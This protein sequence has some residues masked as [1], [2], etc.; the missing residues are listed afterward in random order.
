[1]GGQRLRLNLDPADQ[2]LTI[3]TDGT[4]SV[5][6]GHPRYEGNLVLAR[7]AGFALRGGRSITSEPGRET[8]KITATPR[9]G[10]FGQLG[11]QY[12]TETR[13]IKLGGTAE[14]KFGAKPRF[15]AVLSAR[16]IDIDR[17]VL[18]ADAPQ[19]TPVALLQSIH[20]M[21][22]EFT[23]PSIPVKIGL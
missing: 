22:S 3:E 7:P 11:V 19:R 2:P 12:G 8:S 13:A 18:A 21:F 4:V 5:E 17:A 16:Q 14:L 10:V 15:D 6:A 9:S 20:E 23:R 1:D